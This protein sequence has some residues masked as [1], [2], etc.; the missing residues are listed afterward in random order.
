M[1]VLESELL[2]FLDG[3]T[4]GATQQGP[5]DDRLAT[6]TAR[7]ASGM[8]GL[9][10]LGGESARSSFKCAAISLAGLFLTPF[11]PPGGAPSFSHT[12]FES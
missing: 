7:V 11:V 12:T 9:F 4:Q 8:S 2:V 1:A 3:R 5:C 6:Q 10:E